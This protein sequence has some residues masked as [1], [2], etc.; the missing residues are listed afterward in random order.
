MLIDSPLHVIKINSTQKP[1]LLLINFALL[2]TYDSCIVGLFVDIFY[3]FLVPSIYA[4]NLWQY[5]DGWR[6]QIDNFFI[7]S[8][9]MAVQPTQPP[10]KRVLGF[11]SRVKEA[12]KWH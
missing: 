6:Q 9:N 2:S 3:A 7:T 12:G 5:K 8:F 10:T 4:K 11:F 1:G